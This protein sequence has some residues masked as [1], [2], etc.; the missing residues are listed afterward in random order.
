MGKSLVKF[1][2]TELLS[3]PLISGKTNFEYLFVLNK[4]T[5]VSHD[6]FISFFHEKFLISI[7]YVG[8]LT[9]NLVLLW[10]TLL[11]HNTS[12]VGRVLVLFWMS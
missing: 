6:I 7:A 5:F 11:A 2:S 1:C 4:F 3:F 12:I 9:S 8:S 10:K